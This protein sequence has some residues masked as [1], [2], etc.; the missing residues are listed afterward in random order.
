MPPRFCGES[1]V[2]LTAGAVQLFRRRR[3]ATTAAASSTTAAASATAAAAI[4]R[5]RRRRGHVRRTGNRPAG[6]RWW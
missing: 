5:R 4:H 1:T 2:S 6:I 3:H